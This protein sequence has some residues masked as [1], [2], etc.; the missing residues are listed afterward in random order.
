MKIAIIGAGRVGSTVAYTLIMKNIASHIVMVDIQQERCEGE[1]LDL[2]PS[3]AFSETKSIST[4]N[5][6][7]A[8][9]ANIIIIAAGFAQ[10]PG[11]SRLDLLDKNREIILSIM[12]NL[13]P[14]KSDTIIIMITNPLDIMTLTAQKNSS[15]PTPQI[16]GTGTFIDTIRLRQA[17]AQE[18]NVHQNAIE[19]L[20]IGEH[21]DSQCVVWS[22]SFCNGIP[23]TTMRIK[24]ERLE[25]IAQQVKHEA[26]TIIKKKC[27]TYYGIA[28]CTARLCQIIASDQNEILPLSTYIPEFN[29]CLSVPVI[30]GKNGVKKIMPFSFDEKEISC[31]KKSAEKL[32]SFI[33]K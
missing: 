5:F 27:A 29:I 21:G 25:A 11:E 16:F 1:V 8:R 17:L 28:C 10:T 14:L 33:K 7:D 4:G 12:H 31:L 26:Y 9:T 24:K 20:I 3:I 23:I 6:Q 32:H 30:L 18:L 2:T 15:L 22:H 13:E 19:T